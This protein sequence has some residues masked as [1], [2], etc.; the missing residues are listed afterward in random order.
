M[1][2][3][4]PGFRLHL[5]RSDDGGTTWTGDLRTINQVTNP[6]LAVNIRG[7]AGLLYQRLTTPA[8]G[9]RFET[10]LEIS[11]D[12]FATVRTDVL[13]ANLADQGGIFKQT[14]GDYANLV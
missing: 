12:R 10:H 1:P 8:A 2:A 3:V 14:I 13:L 5:R 11:D 9:N 6:G 7:T 4:A